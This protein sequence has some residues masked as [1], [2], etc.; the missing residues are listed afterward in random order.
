[1]EEINFDL[2]VTPLTIDANVKW[3]NA[4][5]QRIVDENFTKSDS[6]YYN[7]PLY[8]FSAKSK[9]GKYVEMSVAFNNPVGYQLCNEN[10]QTMG[11]LMNC[12]LVGDLAHEVHSFIQILCT[13]DVFGDSSGQFMTQHPELYS[14]LREIFDEDHEFRLTPDIALFYD[15]KYGGWGWDT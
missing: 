13:E 9:S 11:Q 2:M 5:I 15:E 1:M 7:G 12:S 4:D 6:V 8:R 14:Y 10:T 3:V